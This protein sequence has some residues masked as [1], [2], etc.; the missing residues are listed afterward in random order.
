MGLSWGGYVAVIL[1]AIQIQIFNGYFKPWVEEANDW[2]NHQ[3]DTAYEDAKIKKTFYFQM[4]NNYGYVIM[5]AYVKD[6]IFG[7]YDADCLLDIQTALVGIF[8]VR[9]ITWFI[10]TIGDPWTV[11]LSCCGFG[12]TGSNEVE[13][14]VDGAAVYEAEISI[15][16]QQ[17][18]LLTWFDELKEEYHL[19]YKN[20]EKVEDMN[21]PSGLKALGYEILQPS[22]ATDFADTL[23]NASK[24]AP[25]K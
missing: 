22:N 12:G 25:A 1:A 11:L 4:F 24:A 19:A 2:E 16:D 21:D 13:K 7:C 23:H 14:E 9:Y 20:G 17:S 18:V 6:I 8:F 3:T 5:T 10:E 15:E